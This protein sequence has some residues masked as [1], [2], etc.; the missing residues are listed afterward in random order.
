VADALGALLIGLA[1]GVAGG[2]LGLGGGTLYVPALV[3]LLGLGQRDAQGLSLV[4]IVPTAVS[5]TVTNAHA[6]YVDAGAVRWVT[7]L[8]LLAA[9][10]GATLAGAIDEAALTRLFGALLIYVS[11]RM[12]LS[13]WRAGRSAAD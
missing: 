7:P 3:L 6:G 9:A 5:A 8:A 11:A 1:G 12:L 13:E 4:A 10:A 2:L